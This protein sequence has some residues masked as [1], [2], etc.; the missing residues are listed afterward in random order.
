VV[1]A[2]DPLLL[3]RVEKLDGRTVAVTG[4]LSVRAGVKVKQ[5]RITAVR[6]LRAAGER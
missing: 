4:T 6:S 2:G 3:L 5:Q 1:V